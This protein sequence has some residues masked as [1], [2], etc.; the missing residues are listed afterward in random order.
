M[1]KLFEATR[2]AKPQ[3]NDEDLDSIFLFIKNEVL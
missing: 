2:L 3:L 1:S